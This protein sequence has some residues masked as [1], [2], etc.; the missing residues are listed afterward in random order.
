MALNLDNKKDIVEN[1]KATVKDSFSAVVADPRGVV[2]NDLNNLRKISRDSGVK[3][4]IVRNS[5]AI[6]AFDNTEHECLKEYF[7]GPTL[8]ALSQE[9]PGAAAKILS[10]FA[11]NQEQFNIKA[12]SFEGGLVDF[13]FLSKLPTY[14]E[15][16]SKFLMLLKEV[17]A[18][19]LCRVLAAVKD[20]KSG[21]ADL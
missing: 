9:H 16:L 8:V 4:K 19:K 13:E 7:S 5:L 20:Q 15:S 21:N 14:D 2:A 10:E 17:S 6:K 3:V 18:G 12:A 11:K 1:L